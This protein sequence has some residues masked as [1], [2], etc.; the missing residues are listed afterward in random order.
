M[1]FSIKKFFAKRFG[2]SEKKYA[3]GGSA[4]LGEATTRSS[5]GVNT[6]VVLGSRLGQTAHQS[7]VCEKAAEYFGL[8]H[9]FI[10]AEHVDG[11]KDIV[12]DAVSQEATHLLASSDGDA[13]TMSVATMRR[14]ES[15]NGNDN[16]ECNG[17]LL[18]CPLLQSSQAE[19]IAAAI[20]NCQQLIEL[21]VIGF[22]QF[23]GSCGAANDRDNDVTLRQSYQAEYANRG[24]LSV[25]CVA[26]ASNA[27]LTFEPLRVAAGLLLDSASA[28]GSAS[29][30]VRS[31]VEMISAPS[32]PSCSRRR[33]KKCRTAALSALRTIMSK[34]LETAGTD[35]RYRVLVANSGK[36]HDVLGKSQNAMAVLFNV[37]FAEFDANGRRC[38]MG[39]AVKG[40]LAW[41]DQRSLTDEGAG[42]PGVHRMVI[43]EGDA[44]AAMTEVQRTLNE[45]EDE[46]KLREAALAPALQYTRK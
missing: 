8:T 20:K 38:G 46:I 41:G 35:E 43:S 42:A 10:G 25:L 4:A 17:V 6:I 11:L 13:D 21:N 34:L 22:I 23:T 31:D 19:E 36:F 14:T 26:T 3:Q 7:C 39:R 9:L 37:G 15:S 24:P 28:V 32:V 45:I 40:A 29:L 27:F 33:V 18:Y 1:P 30:T 44:Q 5:Q 2:S 12:E 16:D